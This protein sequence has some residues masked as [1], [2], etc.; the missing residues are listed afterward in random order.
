M[1]AALDA[2]GIDLGTCS[3]LCAY[4]NKADK[5]D[6]ADKNAAPVMIPNRWGRTST[7]SVVGWDGDWVVGEDAV[8]LALQGSGSVCWDV[9]RKAG[10]D[11]TGDVLTPL[12]RSLREDAEVFL[13]RFVSSCA[14]AVPESFSPLR[15]EVMTKAAEAAGITNVR[16]VSEPVAA[17]IAFGSEGRF[18]I[19]DFGGASSCISVVESEDGAWRGLES[20]ESAKAGGRDIDLVLAEWLLERLRLD[21]M[22]EDDPRRRALLLEAEAI[23]IA[24]SSCLVYDWKPPSLVNKENR[25]LPVFQVEREELER[26]TRFS[27]RHLLNVTG[28][29][30]DKHQPERLL[31]LGGSSRIPLLREL[32]EREIVPPER[33]SVCGEES[34]AAGAA[35]YAAAGQERLSDESAAAKAPGKRLRDLKMRLVPIEPALNPAQ[36]VRL[37]LMVDKLENLEDNASSMEIMEGIVKNLEAEFSKRSN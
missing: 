31:L 14:L 13:G 30:W 15:R 5:A 4:A 1:K 35:L 12:L 21:P 24:L 11:D 28:R 23:K 26:M 2:V 16:M 34:I 32:L 22:P 29:L 20:I 18:L 6:K 17:A 19:L 37:R 27:V 8:R 7:P 36:K 25:D 3:A 10:E 33:L 9:K